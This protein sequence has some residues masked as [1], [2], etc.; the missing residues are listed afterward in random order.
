MPPGGPGG[1]R[2]SMRSLTRDASVTEQKIPK[3]TTRRIFNFAKPYKKTLIIFLILIVIDAAIGVI[4]PLIYRQIINVGI[5]NRNERLIIELAVL[6]A[7]ISIFD[8]GL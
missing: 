7:V 3:G 1:F 5:L 8:A 4:N 6:A 2:G